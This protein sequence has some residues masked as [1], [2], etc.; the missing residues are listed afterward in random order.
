MITKEQKAISIMLRTVIINSF[1]LF[2]SILLAFLY[3]SKG[4]MPSLINLLYSNAIV[5]LFVFVISSISLYLYD[6]DQ[7]YSK[8]PKNK[9]SLSLFKVIS[10]FIHITTIIIVCDSIL[11][12]NFMGLEFHDNDFFSYIGISVSAIA[13]S[14]FI[15]SKVTLGKNY[16]PCYDQRKP[17]NI[18][19]SGL[20]KYVRHPIYSANI[21]LLIGTFII[22][23]SYLMLINIFLLSLFYAIS[24]YREEKYLINNFDYYNK[25]SK[26]T[27]M[28]LPK[29]R[30]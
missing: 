22:S 30:K 15:S 8:N 7:D 5:L 20:Y 18:T 28:F 29:Y 6:K 23:G 2:T 16:S 24:A 17:K 4:D 21:L 1:A 12:D 27:G 10:K 3:E 13:I 9:I 19:S 25:Y 11:I 14:L 26:K